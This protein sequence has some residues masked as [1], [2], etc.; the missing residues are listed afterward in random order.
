MLNTYST[1]AVRAAEKELLA[2]EPEPDH[3]MR[4]AA[5]AVA[6]AARVISESGRVLVLAGSGGNGGDGLYAGALL[7][8]L[9]QQV[10]AILVTGSAQPRALAAAR[11]AGVT[12]TETTPRPGD[13]DL[14]IDAVAGLGSTRGLDKAYLG[15]LTGAQ[16]LAVD[17]P[18]GVDADSGAAA[19][20]AVSADVTVTFGG[21]R[22]GQAVAAE[23]GQVIVG[24]V[25]GFAEALAKHEPAAYLAYEPMVGASYIWDSP[26]LSPARDTG[27]IPD[28]RPSIHSHKYSGGVTGVCAGSERYPGAGVLTAAGALRATPSM[29]QV[30]NSPGATHRFPEL[31]PAIGTDARVDSW[32]IGPGRGKAAADELVAVLQRP[33]CPVV[34]D[35]DGL[36][37]LAK[38]PRLQ[39]LVRTHPAVLLTPHAAEFAA[40]YAGCV[41]GEVPAGRLEAQENLS[42][43]LDCWVL[44]KGRITTIVG[45]ARSKTVPVGINAGHSLSATA[46]SGDVLSG[47]LG[48]QIALEGMSM[49]AI[50]HAVT[51][52]IHAAAIAATTEYGVSVA[53][54]SQIAE[55]IP[56]AIARLLARSELAVSIPLTSQHA[57]EPGPDRA[58]EQT[59]PAETTAP[60]GQTGQTD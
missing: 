12:I 56:A 29:V 43:A 23:C 21:G 40:L 47:I 33:E 44:H 49:D 51:I 45:P 27:S 35:A 37:Q 9:G 28:P 10:Q 15:L 3:V 34:I 26:F 13:F 30:L 36:H 19:P 6:R 60:T 24:E 42:A 53:T 31:V 14:L 16:V 7:A 50:I 55:A 22:L 8:Q 57:P 39:H 32:V 58:P 5:Q 18:T 52:H 4:A 25:P 48:A 38:S 41:G 1:T 11:E 54:A 20:N 46:G 2:H 17:M 59:D